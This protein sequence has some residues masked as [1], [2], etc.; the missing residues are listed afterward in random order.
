MSFDVEKYKRLFLTESK[1]HLENITK[2]LDKSQLSLS[3]EEV[4]TLFRE[5]HSLKGM[6]AAMGYQHISDLAHSM[7]NIMQEVRIGRQPFDER[8]KDLLI[9]SNDNLWK[10]IEE[11]EAGKPDKS[12]K[13]VS[14]EIKGSSR[15]ITDNFKVGEP[16]VLE[17]S[18][19]ENAPSVLARAFLVYKNI[20]TFGTIRNSLP[21]IDEIKKGSMPD[22]FL[23]IELIPSKTIEPLMTYL[24]K[25]R[26][27]RGINCV[28][29]DSA[30]SK[31][32]KE[33]KEEQKEQKTDDKL[34]LPQSVK[35]DIAFL[36]NFVN[37]TGEL[38]TIKSRIRETTQHIQDIEI[39]NALNQMEILLKDMQEKVMRLRL[40]PLEMIFSRIPRWARDISKKLG[41]KVEV[42]ISGEAIELDRAVVEALFDPVL[43]IIR[44]SVDHGIES[45][46][47]RL[48]FGKTPVGKIVVNAEKERENIVVTIS[49]DG[50][51]INADKV[52]EKAKS[53]GKFS[54]E[55]L[56]SLKTKKDRL[57]LVTYPGITTKEEV[58]DVSGRGVGLDVVKSTI[59]SFGGSFSIDS[60]EGKGTSIK[61]VL[62]SSISIVNVLLFSL[63]K[64][65]FGTPVD[66]IIRILDVKR[67]EIEKIGENSYVLFFNNEHIPL[68]FLH[69]SLKVPKNDKKIELSVILLPVKGVVTAVV[70]DEF[71]GH[72]EVYL[73]PLNP[74]LSYVPGFYSSTILGD[75]S[76]AII[77]D[78]QGVKF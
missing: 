34:V 44:N 56:Q 58:T 39:S 20:E 26:E 6:A 65:L 61:L 55:F 10:M 11:I 68:Y 49:D 71:R 2:I 50:R 22:N 75:G 62:P 42:D 16:I 76:P 53:S 17:I 38:L 36:D 70:V 14:D 41:K 59:E 7:E 24:S 67:D 33:Y 18:F 51:G 73:R 27:I 23:K 9:S 66:K 13:T 46:G 60:E 12:L 64:Y 78:I 28:T 45:P 31:Q 54:E 37:I 8:I 3:E 63:D 69:D 77:L 25:I 43:H 47:E 52:F 29:A 32:D 30:K 35:V 74:P 4:N 40:M 48:S 15:I 72:K 1:E 19:A 57:Y 21:S 5:A